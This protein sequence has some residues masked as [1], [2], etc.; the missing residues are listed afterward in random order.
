MRAG[1]IATDRSRI[2]PSSWLPIG[3][4]VL[5]VRVWA[6]ELLTFA[7]STAAVRRATACSSGL[8]DQSPVAMRPRTSRIALVT[9]SGSRT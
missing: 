6:N 4:P 2:E 5:L 7:V 3:I 9:R 1:F 8:L